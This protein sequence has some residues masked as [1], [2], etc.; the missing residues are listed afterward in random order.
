MYMLAE[1]VLTNRSIRRILKGEIA[2]SRGALGEGA[3]DMAEE[4]AMKA[5]EAYMKSEGKIHFIWSSL[6][7]QTTLYYH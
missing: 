1:S 3:S 2:R 6:H 4:Q 5:V 7:S